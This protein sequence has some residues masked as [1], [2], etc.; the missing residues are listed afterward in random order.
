M[1]SHCVISHQLLEI[2]YN[3]MGR[4]KDT[5]RQGSLGSLHSVSKEFHSFFVRTS[6]FDFKLAVLDI[7]IS[8]NIMHYAQLLILQKT[9]DLGNMLQDDR[10]HVT[11]IKRKFMAI[12]CPD[13][14]SYHV[15]RITFSP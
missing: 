13:C 8:Y 3:W 15:Q 5:R 12:W 6:K 7:P 4:G 1:C 11:A 10:T 9:I 2:S 14:I